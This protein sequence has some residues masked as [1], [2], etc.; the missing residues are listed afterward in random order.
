MIKQFYFKQ[1]NFALL[2]KVKWFQVLLCITNNSIRYL[3]FIK[4]VKYQTVLFLTIQFRISPLFT[5]R[6]DLEAMAMKG[7]S[8]F[9]KV[10]ALLEHHH[11]I[12]SSHIRN[13]RWRE[14]L[15]LCR[16]AVGVFYSPNR[17]SFT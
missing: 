9:P 4:K 3:S 1:F 16:D 10:P 5:L 2:N 12:F 7:Y 15:I 11:P 6:V 13:T 8:G 14:V 17:L